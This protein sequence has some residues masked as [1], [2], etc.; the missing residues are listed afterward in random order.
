MVVEI[1]PF[2]MG[3]PLQD[4][5]TSSVVSDDF[6]SKQ[7]HHVFAGATLPDDVMTQTRC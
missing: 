7:T 1:Y 6:H 5:D 3:T 4:S 2:E